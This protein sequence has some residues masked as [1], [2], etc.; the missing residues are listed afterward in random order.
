MKM[1]IALTA[2]AL[3]IVAAGSLFTIDQARAQRARQTPELMFVDL[4]YVQPGVE[5]AQVEE[6]FSRIAPIVAKHGL[7]RVG[8]FKVAQKM[9]GS[10]EPDF[11]NLWV[12]AG[13]ETFE[14]IFED[15]EY[16]KNIPFRNSTFD[17]ARAHMFML[18]PTYAS[19]K[20]PKAK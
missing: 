2:A 20:F 9:G 10:I 19:V 17:M 12:V 8:S 14:G 6:Y 3:V 4:L 18:A 16:T 13:P 11:L 15:A 1:K 5:D 7:K